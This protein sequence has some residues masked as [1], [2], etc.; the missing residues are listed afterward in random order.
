MLRDSTCHSEIVVCLFLF[1]TVALT[2]LQ[3]K[4]GVKIVQMGWTEVK[5]LLGSAAA[6]KSV[7]A[8]GKEDDKNK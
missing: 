6:G 7:D 5:N 3:F 1:C 4:W 2:Y 8:G